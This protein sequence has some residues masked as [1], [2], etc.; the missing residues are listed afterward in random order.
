MVVD[1]LARALGEAPDVTAVVG[2]AGDVDD[3]VGGQHVVGVAVAVG[4]EVDVAGGPV[5]PEHPLEGAFL[6]VARAVEPS[7]VGLQ[8]HDAGVL[9]GITDDIGEIGLAQ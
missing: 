2:V 5:S 6:G 8:A 9:P 3:I 1:A 7:G 4:H